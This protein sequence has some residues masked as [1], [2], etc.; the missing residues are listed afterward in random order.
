MGEYER[1]SRKR[2]SRGNR[3]LVSKYE[4]RAGE[5]TGRERVRKQQGLRTKGL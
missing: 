3:E 5:E 4:E 1:G 2:R